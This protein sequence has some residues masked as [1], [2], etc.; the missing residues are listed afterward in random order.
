MQWLWQRLRL[1]RTRLCVNRFVF[2][3]G[4]KENNRQ[5]AQCAL[6]LREYNN[7]LLINDTLRMID[8]FSSLDDF[9][10]SRANT[11]IDVTDL[12]LKELF[13]GGY[14]H[15]LV[16]LPDASEMLKLLVLN[17]GCNYYEFLHHAAEAL[18][19][20]CTENR[21]ELKNVV[22]DSRYENPKM[23]KLETV[24]LNQFGPDAKSR[25]ILFSKTRKST[26]CLLDWVSTS[27]SLQAAGI[28]AAILTG[29][30]NGIGNMTHVCS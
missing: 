25:G 2:A 12:F 6:H 3:S 18:F 16:H 15:A 17:S 11:E 14:S 1:R 19:H 9:Y 8:A 20:V 30:G 28:K 10:R 27:S 7:A 22:G 29:A 21:D 5:W 13:R 23:S 26:H 24:L 4:V